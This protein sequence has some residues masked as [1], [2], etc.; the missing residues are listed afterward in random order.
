MP[1]IANSA[2]TRIEEQQD[3]IGLCCGLNGWLWLWL[4]R[5]T[6]QS[7]NRAILGADGGCPGHVKQAGNVSYRAGL[8][9]PS[10]LSGCSKSCL[11]LTVHSTWPLKP[12]AQRVASS[13]WPDTPEV[14]QTFA[15]AS[16]PLEGTWDTATPVDC[17]GPPPRV[18]CNVPVSSPLFN[19]WAEVTIPM[20]FEQ[21]DAGKRS[22]P[23]SAG[24]G[25]T[26]AT[27]TSTRQAQ[28]GSEEQRREEADNTGIGP[29]SWLFQDPNPGQNNAIDPRDVLRWVNVCLKGVLL[30]SPS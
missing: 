14:Q 21:S 10:G 28:A 3:R 12:P 20:H 18:S 23:P 8:T 16:P 1:D 15:K 5:S 27:K 13:Q 24:P 2:S 30:L 9:L 7:F 6:R 25:R 19:P 11:Y 22:S 4:A 29:I 17:M 26:G